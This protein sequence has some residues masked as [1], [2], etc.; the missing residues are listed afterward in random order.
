V[1]PIGSG[2]VS[3][4]HTV[5][6]V[7]G[8]SDKSAI[9]ALAQRRGRDLAAEGISLVAMGGATNIGTYIRRFGPP[10]RPDVTIDVLPLR[11]GA[12]AAM[13]GSFAILDFGNPDEDPPV[14]Y[15]ETASSAAYL[16]KPADLDRHR[17]IFTHIL[18]STIPLQEYSS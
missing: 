12:H 10:G 2:L 9:E 7:E 3:G 18:N 15:V 1:D 16:Q 8:D 6:L 5:V 13:N 14:A 4:A 17:A 11:A